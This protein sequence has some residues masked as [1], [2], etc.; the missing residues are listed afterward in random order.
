M[1]K[2]LVLIFLLSASVAMAQEPCN[3]NFDCDQDVNAQDVTLND[4]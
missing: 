3:G 2:L 1:K 4:I